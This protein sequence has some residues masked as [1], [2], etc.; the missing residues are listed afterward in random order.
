MEL[1]ELIAEMRS[2][3][4]HPLG[5]PIEK[6]LATMFKIS[7]ILRILDALDNRTEALKFY[8]DRCHYEEYTSEGSRNG[9]AWSGTYLRVKEDGAIARAALRDDKDG[10]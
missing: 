1:T 9:L 4:V 2:K 8:A 10:G 5:K 7:D 6:D 3:A